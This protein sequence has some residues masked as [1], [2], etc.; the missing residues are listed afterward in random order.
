MKYLI[1]ITL[2]FFNLVACNNAELQRPSGQEPGTKPARADKVDTFVINKVFARRLFID[3]L[4][5]AK[6]IRVVER[7]ADTLAMDDMCHCP[8]YNFVWVL[9]KNKPGIASINLYARSVNDSFFTEEQSYYNKDAVFYKDPDGN[10]VSEH[11]GPEVFYSF[12]LHSYITQRKSTER[13]ELGNTLHKFKEYG[14][15]R[16]D[17]I[18]IW[19]SLYDASHRK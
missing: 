9:E 8:A 13:N 11:G 3:S 4:I 16:F 18:E 6:K 1:L 10:T 17:D 7:Q 14:V 15:P 19:D 12:N 5:A 2:A